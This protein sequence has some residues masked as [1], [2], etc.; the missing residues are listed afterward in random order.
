MLYHYYINVY[1]D[2]NQ[3]DFE[4]FK[5]LLIKLN[6]SK[7]NMIAPWPDSTPAW[8]WM[9][10]MNTSLYHNWGILYM[11]VSL[12]HPVQNNACHTQPTRHPWVSCDR[13]SK[14]LD[15]HEYMCSSNPVTHQQQTETARLFEASMSAETI[16]CQ[17]VGTAWNCHLNLSSWTQPWCCQPS[18]D[19]ALTGAF[20]SGH[21]GL[22]AWLHPR[23]PSIRPGT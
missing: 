2:I 8:S 13:F 4:R 5:Q 6:A 9:N 3:I 16:N 21:S 19:T 15:F 12:S 7:F 10:L 22:G 14:Q 18:D 23:D 17:A 11:N 1:Q 20:D